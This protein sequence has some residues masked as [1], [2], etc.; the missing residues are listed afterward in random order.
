[1]SK[2]LKAWKDVDGEVVYLEEGQSGEG[3]IGQGFT[4]VPGSD[5][6]VSDDLSTYEDFSKTASELEVTPTGNISSTN[7][8][9][10][11]EEL[12]TDIDNIVSANGSIDTHSDVDTSTVTPV[13]GDFL[14]WDSTANKWEPEASL[15]STTYTYR[16]SF[17]AERGGTTTGK[18]ALGNGSNASTMGVVITEGCK[19]VSV[20]ISSSGT[21][22]GQW[23]IF[24]NGAS[25]HITNTNT[26]LTKVDDLSSPVSLNSGDYLNALCFNAGGAAHTVTFEVEITKTITGLKGEQGEQGTAGSDGIAQVRTGN[27]APSNSLGNDGDLYLNNATGDYYTKVSGVWSLQGNL[28]GP[29]GP[30]SPSVS[31]LKLTNTFANN[32]NSSGGVNYGA[33]N[34]SRIIDDFGSDLTVATSSITFNITGRFRCDFNFFL[35]S[36]SQRTNVLFRWSINGVEQ[37][38]RSAHNYIRRNASH[39]EASSFLSEVLDLSD[40]DVLRISC[41]QIAGSGTVE[42]PSGESIFTIESL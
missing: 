7:V 29:Q 14:R 25:I 27:G 31:I 36:S 9:Q 19:L 15:I 26:Q 33:F 42:T 5:R 4:R 3:I 35:N 11:L 1:M 34:T 8:Q 2:T 16:K 10:S 22:S 39:D 41:V 20:G 38:G 18:L 6:V 30:A 24:R 23:Q 32:I 12:Q 37:R 40:G 21:T 17:V 28:K 13:N